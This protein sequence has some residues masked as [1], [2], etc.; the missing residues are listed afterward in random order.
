MLGMPSLAAV[1]GSGTSF[2][3]G[4]ALLTIEQIE[5]GTYAIKKYL[6]AV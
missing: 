6:I 1:R 4:D 5:E 3:T 2:M